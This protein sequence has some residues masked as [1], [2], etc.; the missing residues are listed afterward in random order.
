MDSEDA[1]FFLR[2]TEAQNKRALALAYLEKT[3]SRPSNH[4]AS[5]AKV[6]LIA[7]LSQKEKTKPAG[8]DNTLSILQKRKMEAVA[9]S[10]TTSQNTDEENPLQRKNCPQII[11]DASLPLNWKAICDSKSGKTYY[12]HIVTKETTW[13]CPR[14]DNKGVEEKAAAVPSDWKEMVHPAT[15]Q[16]YYAHIASGS[17]SWTYPSPEE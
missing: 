10:V 2:E 16:K 6:G 12:W 3:G 15:K 9:V 14:H 11:D 7:A 17:K 13:E 5:I 1:K 8:R 4:Q